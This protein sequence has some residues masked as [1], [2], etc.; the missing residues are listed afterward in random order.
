MVWLEVVLVVVVDVVAAGDIS[1]V[2]E[3]TDML[4]GFFPSM[5]YTRVR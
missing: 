5:L 2:A 1:V 3:E 4:G